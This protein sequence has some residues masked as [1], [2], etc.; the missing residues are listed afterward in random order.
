MS[1][2]WPLTTGRKLFFTAL[3]IIVI[4]VTSKPQT[5]EIASAYLAEQGYSGVILG[6]HAP[7]YG[8]GAKRFPFE[9]RNVEGKRV[10]GELSM[11]SFSWFYT[12]RL[13]SAPRQ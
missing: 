8:R 11:G 7:Y 3:G 13:D 10:T 6:A 5:P 4:L 12:V 1:S 9:A 2:I